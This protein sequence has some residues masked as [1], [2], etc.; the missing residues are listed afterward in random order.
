MT[1]TTVRSR[2]DEDKTV[3]EAC[4]ADFKNVDGFKLFIVFI[5]PHFMS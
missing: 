4:E 2:I 5:L 3:R 1:V